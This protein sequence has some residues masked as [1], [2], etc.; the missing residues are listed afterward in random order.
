MNDLSNYKKKTIKISIILLVSII[1]LSL[2]ISVATL[3]IM[4]NSSIGTPGYVG[5]WIVIVAI[6]LAMI[7][8]PVGVF[9]GLVSFGLAWIPYFVKKRKISKANDNNNN[10]ISKN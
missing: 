1:V 8:F 9:L 4:V 6:I 3:I 2:I 5:G 7:I 10:N